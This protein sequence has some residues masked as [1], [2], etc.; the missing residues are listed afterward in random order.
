MKRHPWKALRVPLAIFSLAIASR[1]FAQ[2]SSAASNGLYPAPDAGPNAVTSPSTPTADGYLNSLDP[3]SDRYQRDLKKA[4][5]ASEQTTAAARRL[6][7]LD[8]D[9]GSHSVG[10]TLS[11]AQRAWIAVLG[12]SGLLLSLAAVGYVWR[13]RTRTSRA[14]AAVLL[15]IKPDPA[16]TPGSPEKHGET[17]K[18]H[19]A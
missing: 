17:P 5:A 8:P 15:A 1:S 4:E 13:S 11:P 19:A 3:E 7:D 16:A 18:R 6:G 10:S 14:T 2:Q 12:G 9:D